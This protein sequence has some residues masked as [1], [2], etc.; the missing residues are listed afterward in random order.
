MQSGRGAWGAA[1]LCRG[2]IGTLTC[3][4]ASAPFCSERKWVSLRYRLFSAN[5]LVSAA[6]GCCLPLSTAKGPSG[7]LNARTNKSC[8]LQLLIDS[9]CRQR[10][11]R[12]GRVFCKKVSV[13]EP[14]AL[15]S[16]HVFPLS[17][18]LLASRFGSSPAS[19]SEINRPEPQIVII[20]TSTP[21]LSIA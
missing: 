4:V 2:G 7:F 21:A 20:E 3:P 15:F 13:Q 9:F 1:L 19:S 12:T 6:P 18:A 16:H 17:S 10:V 11:T 14:E 5:S 8:H